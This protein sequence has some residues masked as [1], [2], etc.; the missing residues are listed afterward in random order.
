MSAIENKTQNRKFQK[1]WEMY[2]EQYKTEGFYLH[3]VLEVYIPFWE[4]TQSVV[5]EKSV[6]IDR[7]SRIILELVK[8][9][10]TNHNEI[11]LFLGI[12]EDDFVNIQFHFLLKNNLLLENENNT[13]KITVDGISFLDKKAKV[14]TNETTNFEFFTIERLKYMKGELSPDFFD[15]KVPIDIQLSEEKKKQFSAYTVSQTHRLNNGGI[16]IPHDNRPLFSDINKFRSDFSN[17][18]HKKNKDKSFYDFANNELETHKRSVAFLALWYKNEKNPEIEK[19]DIRQYEKSIEEFKGVNE[20]EN[21][22]SKRMTEYK[23]SHP[24]CFEINK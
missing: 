19:V 8:N 13:Y 15:P 22:L 17:F 18:F 11:C 9:G 20:I 10:M 23:K 24:K 14:M 3:N 2:H 12:A 21:Y 1:V 7:F 4:C 16:K 6:E 5:I